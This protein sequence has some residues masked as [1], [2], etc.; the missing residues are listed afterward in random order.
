MSLTQPH[1]KRMEL[2]CTDAKLCPH[3]PTLAIVF[4]ESSTKRT[5]TAYCTLY[6][7]NKSSFC[8]FNV[9]L[10]HFIQLELCVFEGKKKLFLHTPSHRL[11]GWLTSTLWVKLTR[12]DSLKYVWKHFQGKA[13]GTR[14]P[15]VLFF[16]CVIPTSFLF[17]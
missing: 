1:S 9:T 16:N 11:Q 3:I 2:C 4:L 7:T 15:P 14:F 10:N 5:C 8:S 12:L 17:L 13:K 6:N